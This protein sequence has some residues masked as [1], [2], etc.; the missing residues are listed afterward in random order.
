MDRSCYCYGEDI[1]VSLEVDNN[2][3]RNMEKSK[4]K[5]VQSVRYKATGSNGKQKDKWSGYE[6]NSLKGKNVKLCLNHNRTDSISTFK[7]PYFLVS[8]SM[9]LVVVYYFAQNFTLFPMV[10]IV[11]VENDFQKSSI[12]YLFFCLNSFAYNV[13]HWP[14]KFFPR[15]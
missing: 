15:P 14:I 8:L 11:S 4:V 1:L 10:S 13:S 5:L 7:W 9:G 3:K 6:I 2:T 12:F